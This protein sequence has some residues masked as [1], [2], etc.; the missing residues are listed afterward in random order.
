MHQIVKDIELKKLNEVPVAGELRVKNLKLRSNIFN[1][2][3]NN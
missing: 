1:K 2:P 3:I